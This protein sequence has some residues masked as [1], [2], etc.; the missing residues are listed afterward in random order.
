[1][2]GQGEWIHM[3]TTP[4]GTKAYVR[5]DGEGGLILR[6]EQPIDMFLERN[7]AMAN[8]NDGWSASR[9]FRRE[10][11][12]PLWLAEKWKREEGVDIFHASGREFLKRRLNDIDYLHLRTS[13]GKT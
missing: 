12:I 5:P 2:A 9:D 3:W 7:K 8:H 10:G 13:P 11:S 1:M 4:G 6:E